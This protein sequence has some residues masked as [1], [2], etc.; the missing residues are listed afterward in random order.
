MKHTNHLYPAM[1]LMLIAAASL[2][3][4][5]FTSQL[6]LNELSFTVVAWLRFLAPACMMWGFIFFKKENPFTVPSFKPILIRVLFAL[7]T[8][9]SFI[10]SLSQGS[11]LVSILLMNTGPLF[12]PLISLGLHKTKLSVGVIAN[13]FLSFLGVLLVLVHGLHANSMSISFGLL[14]GFSNACSQVTMHKNSQQMKPLIDNLWVFSISAAIAFPITFIVIYF[15]LGTA[16]FVYSGHFSQIAYILSLFIASGILTTLTQTCRMKAYQYV[17]TPSLITPGIYFA[18]IVSALI[19]WLYLDISLNFHML[20]G[21][22]LIIGSN[23]A[24]TIISNKKR[25]KY[26]S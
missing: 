8:Q 15:Q 18:V 14:A 20:L 21:I 24:F 23:L 22:I 9:Y 11:L 2:A 4:G 25:T 17:S 13:T 3:L 19:D 6:L 12:V 10:T 1:S 26:I 5:G 7:L 16:V